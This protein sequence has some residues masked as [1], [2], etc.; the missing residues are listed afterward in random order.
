MRKNRSMTTMILIVVL[1]ASPM[2]V[3]TNLTSP[4]HI[5]QVTEANI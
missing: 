2:V 5:L 1:A 4:K 3:G